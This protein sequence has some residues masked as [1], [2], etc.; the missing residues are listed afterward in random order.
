MPTL[1]EREKLSLFKSQKFLLHP[2]PEQEVSPGKKGW[3]VIEY[4]HHPKRK[5]RLKMEM[6]V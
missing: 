6:K 2:A 1:K 5:I 3:I 4:L